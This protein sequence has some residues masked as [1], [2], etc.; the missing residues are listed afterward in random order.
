MRPI[1]TMR[2]G[3]LFRRIE[4]KFDPVGQRYKMTLKKFWIDFYSRRINNQYGISYRILNI[5]ISCE[6]PI[7]ATADKLGAPVIIKR[8]EDNWIDIFDY[9]INKSEVNWITCSESDKYSY[10]L[11]D[12][13]EA[14]RILDIELDEFEKIH[15]SSPYS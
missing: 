5:F 1:E 2:G 11:C 8:L 4:V 12:K 13:E 9:A 7:I 3:Y 6:T 10:D 15:Q 14:V